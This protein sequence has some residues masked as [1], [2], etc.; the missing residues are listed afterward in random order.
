VLRTNAS[1]DDLC[2]KE[3]VEPIDTHKK[4]NTSKGIMKVKEHKDSFKY[5]GMPIPGEEQ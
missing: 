4:E 1:E 5:P 2:L 3:T